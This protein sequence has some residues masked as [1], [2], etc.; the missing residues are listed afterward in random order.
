MNPQLTKDLEKLVAP[1]PPLKAGAAPPKSGLLSKIIPLIVVLVIAFFCWIYRA[2]IKAY[3]TPAQP[4][5]TG[6]AAGRNAVV[7][8]VAAAAKTGDIHIF[9]T[10]L[11]QVTPFETEVVHTRV[12]GQIMK[13]NFQEGQLVHKDDSLVDIDPRPYQTQLDQANGQIIK[14]QAILAN[15]R[16]DLDRDQQALKDGA[17]SDQTVA[18]QQA[19][20]KQYEGIV[21]SDQSQID[22]AKLNLVYCHVLAGIDGRIGLRQIDVGNIVHATDAGGLATITKLQPIAVV[23]TLPEDDLPQVVHPPSFGV[24]LEVDAFDRDDLNRLTTGK[25]EAVDNQ[26][27]PASGT[28][29]VKAEFENKDSSLFPNQFVN[30]HLLADTKKNVV[31]VPTA[32]VQ[33]GPDGSPF[34]YVIRPDQTAEIRNITEGPAEG[35]YTSVT[36]IQP[37]EIVVTDGTDKLVDGS[38]VTVTMAG[39][40]TQPTTRQGRGRRNGAPPIGSGGGGGRT[41]PDAP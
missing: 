31:L 18:T 2:Q 1:P 33:H 26:V 29:K 9:L 37:R 17:I 4:A 38:K 13:I 19:T 11:G 24:G 35:D 14:D 12:D 5:A 40:T 21:A 32:A 36:G 7:S 8:V 10:G 3:I 16:I 15:A 22:N 39:G 30:A 25:V 27:D 41:T 6:R 23:F 20:V 28:F 34:A